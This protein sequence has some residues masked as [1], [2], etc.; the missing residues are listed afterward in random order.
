M[1]QLSGIKISAP[2]YSDLVPS[3][4][5]KVKLTPFRVG[6][7]KTLMI[8]AQSKN[9]KQMIIALKKVIS[10]CVEPVDVDELAPFD[11]EY[12]FLKLRAVSIGETAN[13]GIKCASC[14]EVNPYSIDLSKIKV[15]ET[16]GH[17]S[18]IKI[19]K[20]LAFE[21]K[22]PDIDLIDGE[23]NQDNIDQV[24]EL[25]ASSVK[26]VF[27]NEDVIEVGITDRGD[28]IEMLDS[29]STKQF[30]KIQEFFDT[31]PKLR[32]TIS[33]SCKSCKTQNEQVLEGLSSFF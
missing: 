26:K 22:Y 31:A 18:M 15:H 5:Q 20:E 10:N 12:L 1:G 19:S 17:T 3:T 8:A 28:L 4:K 9:T 13:I 6:D 23:F 30:S 27:Y 32:E 2:T 25:V 21:M 7:E 24:F 29:L 14:E 16:S 11:L 33:F